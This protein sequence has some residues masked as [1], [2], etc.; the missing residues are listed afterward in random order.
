[1][2]VCKERERETNCE[3]TL[4][5]PSRNIQGKRKKENKITI[6]REIW[7]QKIIREE[8]TIMRFLMKHYKMLDNNHYNTAGKYS[9][10]KEEKPQVAIRKDGRGSL[11]V[12]T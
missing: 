9:K 7:N 8:E 1:M 5:T 3:R 11:Q 2:C 10:K 12:K 4:T 6:K